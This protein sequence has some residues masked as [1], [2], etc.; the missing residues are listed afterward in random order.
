MILD[1]ILYIVLHKRIG[2]QSEGTL[3]D[4]QLGIRVIV[5]KLHGP[6]GA[7]KLEDFGEEI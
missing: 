5:V 7:S 1:K 3:R 4:L 6:R 2:H